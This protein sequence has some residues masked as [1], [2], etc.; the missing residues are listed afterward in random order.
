MNRR[1][2]L[3]AAGV[4]GATGLAGCVG[5]D[6]NG[7]GN[8]NGNGG[9]TGG[10]GD[11]DEITVYTNIPFEDIAN[12]Y[13]EA[14]GV[15]V[16]YN[17]LGGP[18]PVTRYVAEADQEQYG[19][20][21]ICNNSGVT[22]QLHDNDIPGELNVD[23][24]TIESVFSLEGMRDAWEDALGDDVGRRTP[25]AQLL[26]NGTHYNTD[27]VSDPPVEYTDFLNEQ[28]ENNI[29]TQPY[30][31]DVVLQAMEHYHGTETAEQWLIDY[32]AQGIDYLAGGGTL[33]ESLL[34][35]ENMLAPY[36]NGFYAS[37]PINNGAPIDVVF[38]RETYYATQTLTKPVN[39]PNPEGADDFIEWLLSREGQEV[40][41]TLNGGSL[42]AHEDLDY[43]ND[44]VQQR[45]D[46][47]MEAY[48]DTPLYPSIQ[49]PDE[50]WEYANRT[51]ELID[52]EIL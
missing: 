24:D 33:I 43:G 48:P 42:P 29:T 47:R 15:S 13:E 41:Q 3:T 44:Q 32:D 39:A 17:I 40:I 5:G 6:G 52:V 27:L 7:N 9:T 38:P 10:N 23:E 30:I 22:W 49:D 25:P 2:F 19:V 20:D 35:E 45:L 36:T 4:A 51:E 21:V 28:F 11:D 50:F 34:G 1:S 31:Q 16:N 46:E 37:E 8:G 18:Q 12:A 26:I 14:A